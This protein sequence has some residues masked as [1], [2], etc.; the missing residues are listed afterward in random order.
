MATNLIKKNKVQYFGV[1]LL[2][3]DLVLIGDNPAIKVAAR[4]VTQDFSDV[5]NQ[6]LSAV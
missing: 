6:K 3:L 1:I 5:D 4:E 2:K